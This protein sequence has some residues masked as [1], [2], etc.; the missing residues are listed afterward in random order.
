LR[1]RRRSF[2]WVLRNTWYLR[3]HSRLTTGGLVTRLPT[4]LDDPST[5]DTART[6][7]VALIDAALIDAALA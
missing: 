7:A 3:P 4:A 1:D 5:A 2:L 6:I